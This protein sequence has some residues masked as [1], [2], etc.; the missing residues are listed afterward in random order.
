MERQAKLGA[1]DTTLI[2]L[3]LLC[4]NARKGLWSFFE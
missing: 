2:S 1:Y 4:L 3:L